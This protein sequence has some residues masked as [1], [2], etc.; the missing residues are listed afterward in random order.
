MNKI[1]AISLIVLGLVSAGV[2]VYFWKQGKKPTAGLRVD[3]NPTSL[4]FVDN[5]QIGQSPVDKMYIPGEVSVKLIPN[6]TDSALPSYQTKVKL[7]AN[8][9]T[10]IKRDFAATE[11][12]SAGDISSL[13]TQSSKTATL[14]IVTASPDSASVTL[15]GLP[16]GFTPLLV[17]AVIPGEH[18][19]IVSAPGYTDRRIS[20]RAVVGY[21][22]TI[23]VKLA[24]QTQPLPTPTPEP[25]I[26]EEDPSASPSPS[27]KVSPKPKTSPTPI[28]G[29]YVTIKDTDTGWLRVRESF[30]TKSKELGRVYPG[31]KYKLLST[32]EISTIES[33]YQIRVD[34][35]ATNSGWI[36]AKYAEKSE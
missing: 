32:K 24:G 19:I 11:I 6:A 36:S 28:T 13:E 2:G 25:E 23:N 7:T 8:T 33:W 26:V 18:E 22:L 12:E 35:D 34:L 14:V 27:P 1:I 21:K 17:S 10:V 20:A 15:D 4:V 16:Q 9:L 5:A 29:S 30:N 31:D 3:T